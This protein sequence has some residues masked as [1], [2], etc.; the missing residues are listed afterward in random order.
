[1][2]IQ[3]HR[4]HK[5][6]NLCTETQIDIIYAVSISQTAETPGW[7]VKKQERF[8]YLLQNFHPQT[9]KLKQQAHEILK[10]V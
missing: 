6:D 2:Y 8:C 10:V 3:E 5:Q 4:K 1:M 9:S 7:N